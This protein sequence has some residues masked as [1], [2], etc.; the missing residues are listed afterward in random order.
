[1]PESRGL[2]GRLH[3]TVLQGAGILVSHTE[4]V[5]YNNLEK[6]SQCWGRFFLQ[7]VWFDDPGGATVLKV[8]GGS[9][10]CSGC[11]NSASRVSKQPVLFFFLLEK[12][13]AYEDRV[14]QGRGQGT[15]LEFFLRWTLEG[16]CNWSDFANVCRAVSVLITWGNA[17]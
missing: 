6:F 15:D 13:E 10:V 3:F 1:M 9:N 12:L 14:A 7:W 2:L 4:V 8:L 17:V 16:L 5:D 11:R